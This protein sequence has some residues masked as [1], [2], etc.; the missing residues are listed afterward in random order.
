[1]G[2]G[3]AVRAETDA[4]RALGGNLVRDVGPM[5]DKAA[6]QLDDARGILHSN[7][8]SVT[9]A[10]A[11]TYAAAVEYLDPELGSK[12]AYLDDLRKRLDAVAGNWELTERRSTPALDPRRIAGPMTWQ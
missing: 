9:P 11:I 5:L 3:D 6:N 4:I 12:R 7:F 2:G 8:T 10:L 1:M